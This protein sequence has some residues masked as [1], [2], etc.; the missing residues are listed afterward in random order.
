MTLK[1]KP[2]DNIGGKGEN[3]GKQH[4]LLLPQCFLPFQKQISILQ[5]HLLCRLQMLSIWM[6]P[7]ILSLV[8]ELNVLEMMIYVSG[9]L[10][11]LWEKK[12]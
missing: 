5:S 12:S 6:N 4:F 7:K 1:K 3:A 10:K 8:R 11:I 2:V 9:G